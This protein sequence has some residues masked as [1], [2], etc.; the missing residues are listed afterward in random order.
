MLL[1]FDDRLSEQ[2][3]LNSNVVGVLCA[4]SVVVNFYYMVKERRVHWWSVFFVI[5]IIMVSATGSRQALA[6]MAGGLVFFA[7][8]AAIRDKSP[9]EILLVVL[10]GLVFVFVIFILLSSLPAFTGI[11]KRVLHLLSAVTGVG[12]TDHSATTRLALI[13]VG[14]EQ[15]KRKPILGVG[16][17]SGHLVAWKYLQRFYYLHN[18]YVEIMAGGGIVGFLIYYSIYFYIFAN[19][20]RYRKNVT[21]ETLVCA[22]ILVMALVEDYAS[23]SYYSKE[24][25][26]YL[27]IGMLTVEK[28]RKEYQKQIPQIQTLQ[29]EIVKAT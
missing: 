6:V 4:M 18:N 20:I 3:F 13:D 17:G 15:F 28:L 7:F 22:T 14:F 27:M 2:F 19:M 11:Y 26:F 24:T 25:Y 12:K 16:M 21:I 23:V 10:F 29:K 5:G 9:T 1:E 8:L